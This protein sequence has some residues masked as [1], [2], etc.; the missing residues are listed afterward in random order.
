[1]VGHGAV[2][3][4]RL[5]LH[6]VILRIAGVSPTFIDDYTVGH[7]SRGLAHPVPSSNPG[8]PV[9]YSFTARVDFSSR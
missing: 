2:K 1:L 6:R 5:V 8:L 4:L 7:A 9:S 3:L